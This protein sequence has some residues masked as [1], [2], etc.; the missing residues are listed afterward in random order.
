M[1]VSWSGWCCVAP[2]VTITLPP[3]P[4]LLCVTGS[5]CY[6]YNMH[7]FFFSLFLVWWRIAY[8]SHLYL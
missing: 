2:Q 8:S 3:F 6:R 7:F 1:I 5:N 4:M